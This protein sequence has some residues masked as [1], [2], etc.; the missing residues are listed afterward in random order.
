[1]YLHIVDKTLS[2]KQ[3]FQKWR[4]CGY[5]RLCSTNISQGV[6]GGWR[7]EG[8]WNVHC[9]AV[10]SGLEPR[11]YSKGI[12]KETKQ[13][14]SYARWPLAAFAVSKTDHYLITSGTKE[15]DKSKLR[16]FQIPPKCTLMKVFMY[17]LWTP[18]CSTNLLI[19]TFTSVHF[20]RILMIHNS[21]MHGMSHAK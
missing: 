5:L 10:E 21:L 17:V 2:V 4:R 9:R 20:V 1:M 19:G 6:A 7:G 8:E 18:T 3:Q 13:R 16:V 12:S 15:K 11:P 14:A